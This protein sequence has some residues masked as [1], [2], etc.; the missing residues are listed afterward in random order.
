MGS[1]WDYLFNCYGNPSIYDVSTVPLD[2]YATMILWSARRSVVIFFG[3]EVSARRTRVR[4]CLGN[5]LIGSKWNK[6]ITLYLWVEV[7]WKEN[8]APYN[9][10]L[11]GW[12]ALEGDLNPKGQVR[13][14][15]NLKEHPSQYN[16]L[17]VIYCIM[18]CLIYCHLLSCNIFSFNPSTAG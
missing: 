6:H 16:I 13:P 5:L 2:L 8:W 3:F 1:H 7:P 10:V 12:G 14:C 4:P 18:Y 11:M 15:E 17:S 9:F